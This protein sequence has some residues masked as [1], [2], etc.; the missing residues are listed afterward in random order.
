VRVGKG[1]EGDGC[2]WAETQ[3]GKGLQGAV[4]VLALQ[5]KD[6]IEV[7]RGAQ[8]GKDPL[9]SAAHRGNSTRGAIGQ[10]AFDSGARE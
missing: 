1:S 4:E 2:L 7:Q 5:V 8:G 10:P 3:G 9:D 6:Q